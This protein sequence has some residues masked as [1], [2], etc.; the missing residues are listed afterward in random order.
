MRS[1]S[2]QNDLIRRDGQD[3]GRNLEQLKKQ[4]ENLY[5]KVQTITSKSTYEINQY[6]KKIE[7]L[8]TENKSLREELARQ[9]ESNIEQNNYLKSQYD[10]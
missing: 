10:S 4:N 1:L 9:N 3:K 2:E 5:D 7:V 6:M 8:Q